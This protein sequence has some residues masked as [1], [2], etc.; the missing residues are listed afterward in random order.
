LLGSVT[1]VARIEKAMSAI[2][3]GRGFLEAGVGFA[4]SSQNAHGS[5][6]R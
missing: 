4:D 5:R 3:E 6:R 1:R 2:F